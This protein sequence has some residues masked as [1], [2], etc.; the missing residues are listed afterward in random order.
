MSQTPEQIRADIER[1]RAELGT[2]V[3]AV[4][5]KV[6]PSNIAHR[7]TD[8][9]KHAAGNVKDKIMGSADNVKT[10]V[11]GSADS[12]GGAVHDAPHQLTDKAK[13]NPLAAG[14]IAFG[15]GMLVASLIPASEK[16]KDAASALK[17]KAQPLTT[18]ITDSAKQVMDD[19]KEPAQD[20]VN[21]VKETAADSAQTVK[22]EGTGAA[23]DLKDKSQ[24]AKDNVQ[25]SHNS[26]TV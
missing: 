18:E 3:D 21:S 22:D 16:E 2:D 6:N 4:A 13:G 25:S 12:A 11:M 26:G 24:D 23:S 8:K 7:Q 15:A 1:T 14:L 20:A 5:D 19:M 17:D 10:N 9:V